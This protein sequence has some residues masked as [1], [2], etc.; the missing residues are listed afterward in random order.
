MTQI[1]D[2]PPENGKSPNEDRVM[3]DEHVQF[4]E[5]TFSTGKNWMAPKHKLWRRLIQ[6]YKLEFSIPGLNKSRVQKVSQFYP[7]TR[8][9]LTSVVH[10]NPK[11]LF[12]VENNNLQMASEILERVG[13]DALDLMEVKPEV[14]QMLF[15]SLY[16]YRGWLKA[17][18]N[19]PG[20]DDIV[21]PYTA[22]DS[23]QN[24]MVYWMR[25]N[26]F[27]IYPDPMTPP[28]K[29]GHGRFIWEEMLVPH[30]W[31]MKDARFRFKEEIKPL[32]EEDTENA[33][34]EETQAKPFASTEEE[35]AW[36]SSR[37]DGKYVRLR[38]VHDRQH[39][40]RYTFA[41]G[42]RQPIEDIMHPFLAGKVTMEQDPITGE[43][44]ISGS[45]FEPTGGYLVKNGFPYSSLALDMSHDELYGLPMM[46]Y[47]ED[48]QKGIIES[49][50]RR[51][52][53][54]N[55]ATRIILGRRGERKENPDIDKDITQGKDM[56]IAWVD[57][58]NNSFNELQQGNPP[59]DQLGIESDLR[60]YQEQVLNVSSIAAGGGPKLTATQASLQA[61]FGQLNRDWM[62]QKVG[63]VYEE[64]VADTLRIM[65]DARYTPKNFLVN[66]A[67]SEQDPVFQAVTG[68]ML[69]ARYK[70]H[71]ETG[72]MKPMFE[73][74][75]K[76]DALALFNYLI[77]LPEI[78]RPEAIKYLLRAFRVPNPEKLIGDSSRWDAMRTAETENELMIL[79][80]LTGQPQ[81]APVQPKDDHQG[82]MP[83]HQK[84][85]Q[86]SQRF[87]Q[88]PPELQSVVMQVVQMHTQEHMQY[89]QEAAAG[90]GGGGPP[91]D[92]TISSTGDVGGGNGIEQA[93]SKIDSAVRS[94]AQVI[95]QPK[96]I[97]RNQN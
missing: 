43:Q 53:L 68:D 88:L 33:I 16:C 31:V 49:L 21:P 94:S 82:H 28:H 93:T 37:L 85:Q 75:E 64:V 89:L 60:Q 40:R 63:D 38:E 17:G 59:P 18:I 41:N 52:S 48:T 1:P 24:G 80:A 84:I 58:V 29:V 15:D 34:L 42:V 91:N 32:N 22:N 72:S 77:S 46:A 23:M 4:W 79:W 65:A 12:R 45:S 13:T 92:G 56:V 35:E 57:D 69:K 62:Q 19:P 26:P 25:V 83:M 61:S 73:E 66:V 87:L 5:S 70:I 27:N 20:D 95:S 8:M 9:I 76:E 14:Q 11:V 71:I 36:K 50:S 6:Q 10:Q 39:R 90:G 67:K 74:L 54:L 86:N 51:K 96:N 78:P 47:A 44:K 2:P 7:L 55:R 81:S 3:L 97:D 30:E